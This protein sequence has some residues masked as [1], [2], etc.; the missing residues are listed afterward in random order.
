MNAVGTNTAPRIS[1]TAT[2][3]PPTSSIKAMEEVG[4]PVVAVALIL[5]AV[6]VPTAFI[7]GI[8]GRLYQ[9]FAVTIAVSVAFS[10]FNAMTL[11]PALS[12]MLLRS[13]KP[14]RGPLGAFF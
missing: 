14:S 5:G 9:Q 3:G 12:A 2:T 8:T 7:S 13:K 6:F 11:S 4:G 1:A 10:A